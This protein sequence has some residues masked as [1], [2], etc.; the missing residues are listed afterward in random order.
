MKI[1]TNYKKS[2]ILEE[3]RPADEY[4]GVFP[5]P[6]QYA[7]SV[8]LGEDDIMR[9]RPI[10]IGYDDSLDQDGNLQSQGS[11]NLPIRRS[12]TTCIICKKICI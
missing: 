4:Q 2:H 12:F 1:I 8:M 3:Y 7:T 9:V 6:E 10:K 5:N 11:F